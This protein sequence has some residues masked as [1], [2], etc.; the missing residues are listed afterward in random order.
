MHLFETFRTLGLSFTICN[1]DKRVKMRREKATWKSDIPW[2]SDVKM[3]QMR[4]WCN[5]LTVLA[6][7]AGPESW[8]FLSAMYRTGSLTVKSSLAIGDS[9]AVS[10]HS[11]PCQTSEPRK[12]PHQYFVW[13]IELVH[14]R[15]RGTIGHLGI[16]PELF[17]LLNCFLGSEFGL[18][19]VHHWCA[20]GSVCFFFNDYN[21]NQS[22]SF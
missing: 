12:V 7:L 19:C 21:P 13:G 22:T 10:V 4:N 14:A 5:S 11:I 16:C 18:L 3:R 6:E 8:T 20:A 17:K 15:E 9:D 2:K 1:R